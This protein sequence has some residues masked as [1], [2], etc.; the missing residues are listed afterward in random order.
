MVRRTIAL[1][2]GGVLLTGCSGPAAR[3]AQPADS[4]DLAAQRLD[5]PFV[6][7]DQ[8]L[9]TDD[10]AAYSL[11]E[12]PDKPLTL[13]FFGYTNCP[14]ICGLVMSNI[15]TGYAQLGEEGQEHVDVVFVT[16]D[17]ARD[18]D[19]VVRDYVA[20][21]NDDFVGLTG[22]LDDIIAVGKTMGIA[23]EQGEK[24]ES[25]GYDITHGTQV[26][27]LGP[28]GEV[29]AYWREDTSAGE[30]RADIE[31]LLEES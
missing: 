27:A 8:Q 10:G 19:A 13:V 3:T 4:D 20:Q 21:Y 17:P 5:P 25:G 28:D 2:I 26:M 23:V 16:T 12:T 30:Y 14:D 31:T 9:E 22:D 18:T 24:L 11:A 15:A 1:L 6:V 7:G 29:D